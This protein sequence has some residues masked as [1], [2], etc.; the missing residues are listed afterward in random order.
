MT[1]VNGDNCIIYIGWNFGYSSGFSTA[2]IYWTQQLHLSYY[3]GGIIALGCHIDPI[4][5]AVSLGQPYT[6]SLSHLLYVHP[7]SVKR[8][9]FILV[10]VP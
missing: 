8:A 2:F 4:V 6:L 5:T 9:F 10:S 3:A 1:Q 7:P